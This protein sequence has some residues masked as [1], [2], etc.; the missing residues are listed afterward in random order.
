MNAPPSAPRRVDESMT[1]LTEILE[2]PL[3]PAYGALA[4]RRVAAGLPASRGSRSALFVVTLVV[5]GSVIGTGAST[6]RGS[7]T[8]RAEARSELIRQIDAA[9]STHDGRAARVAA[10]TAE[11]SARDAQ[12]LAAESG[13]DASRLRELALVTGS[14]TVTGP[15]LVVTLDNAPDTNAAGNNSD[16]RNSARSQDGVVRARDLQIVANS[17]WMAGAE[18]IMINGQR[19]T[20]TSAIR[21]AGEAILVND[22]M[23]TN[24]PHVYAGGDVA[25]GPVLSA[26]GSAVH[27]I[28]PT[29][30]DHGRVAGANMASHEVR[31]PGSLA[32]NIVD[33][34]GLQG[35]SFGRWDDALSERPTIDHPLGF[36]YRKL[37]FRDDRISGAIFVGRADDLGMLTDIGM[38]KG[39]MQTATRLGP[40]RKYLQDHPHDIRRA[41]VATGAAA[42]LVATTLLGRPAQ[43]RQFH[44]GSAAP[45]TAANAAHAVFVAKG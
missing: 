6:L 29:A 16:P 37:V 22:R 31:Y 20:A 25:Q 32:M 14:A 44:S 45:T 19:L 1:L 2:R 8:A 5:L 17:L 38:V 7:A 4:R 42:K 12:I 3:D 34:G 26:A 40:W 27:P 28:Q 9:R 36:I 21:F 23:Q 10:L 41:Y 13:E 15:G 18:A 39:L 30:V 24:F 43:A 11:V 33:I 35:A